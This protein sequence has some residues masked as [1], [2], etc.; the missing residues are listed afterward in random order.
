MSQEQNKNRVRRIYEQCL[1]AGKLE[2]LDDLVAPEF[3]GVQGE[4]GP[5]GFENTLAGLR[6]AYPD[7]HFTIEDMIAEGDRV[8]I[9]WRWAGTQT[10]PQRGFPPS[11]AA[12]TDTGIAIYELRDGKIIRAWLETDRLGVLQQIGVVPSLEELRASAA[13]RSGD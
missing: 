1:N 12:V 9:R 3:V 6:T 4:R 13:A 5:D 10:G 2:L 7:I 8:A 11:G